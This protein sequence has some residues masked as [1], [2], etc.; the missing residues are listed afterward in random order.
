[1][2]SIAFGIIIVLLPW[3]AHIVRSGPLQTAF[4]NEIK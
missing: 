3:I 1:M 2:D 4:I